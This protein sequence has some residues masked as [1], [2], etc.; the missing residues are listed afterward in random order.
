MERLGYVYGQVM[1]RT[2]C[3][4][5]CH[6]N[7]AADDDFALADNRITGTALPMPTLNTAGASRAIY[8]SASNLQIPPNNSVQSQT[9]HAIHSHTL[10]HY[11]PCCKPTTT[12]PPNTRH[13]WT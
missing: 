12:Q 2:T 6:D 11:T 3:G 1:V 8:A 9:H 7:L 10:A 4:C 5:P 13:Q